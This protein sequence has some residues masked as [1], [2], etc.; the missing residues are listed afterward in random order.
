MNMKDIVI[1]DGYELKKF[2]EHMQNAINSDQVHTI[3]F[4]V[5]DG[6]K[7]KVN[8]HVWTPPYGKMDV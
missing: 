7:I 2:L 4:A 8:Q 1:L 6:L 5:E 3:R